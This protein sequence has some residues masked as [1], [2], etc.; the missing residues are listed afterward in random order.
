LRASRA[1]KRSEGR[2]ATG[3]A[4]SVT[5]GFR[6]ERRIRLQWGG[7]AEAPTPVAEREG[8]LHPDV[9]RVQMGTSIFRRRATESARAELALRAMHGNSA[10]RRE[11]EP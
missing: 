5:Q 2:G 1:V 9:A 10:R 7:G 11:R 6:E 4:R 8:D 3:M